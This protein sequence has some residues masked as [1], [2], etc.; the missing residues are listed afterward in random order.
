MMLL[1]NR[2]M[3]KHTKFTLAASA[4]L[5]WS[6]CAVSLSR[7]SPADAAGQPRLRVEHVEHSAFEHRP[8]GQSHR[9]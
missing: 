1:Q 6:A 2:I 4:L 8:V 3:K 9:V 7:E 5:F